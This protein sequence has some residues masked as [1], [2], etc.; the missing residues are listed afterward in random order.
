[1]KLSNVIFYVADINRAVEFYQKIGF[2]IVQ[3]HDKYIDLETTD[4][5]VHLSLRESNGDRQSPGKQACIFLTENVSGLYEKYKLLSIPLQNDLKTTNNGRTFAI[6]D[7]DG[8][9]L[10]FIQSH[11]T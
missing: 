8:N 4:P 6:T 3:N 10:E 7:P 9:R 11:L 1:M 2:K 5:E